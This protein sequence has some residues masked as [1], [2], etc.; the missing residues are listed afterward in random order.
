MNHLSRVE[1]SKFAIEGY[2]IG[3]N[4]LVDNDDDDD[5]DD[6]NIS[7]RTA[8][9]HMTD[10]LDKAEATSSAITGVHAPLTNLSGMTGEGDCDDD[11]AGGGDDD[12]AG[13]DGAGG[14]DDCE[15]ALSRSP[16]CPFSDLQHPTFLTFH[17]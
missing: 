5:I 13:A 8:V 15:L 1:A 3:G 9:D 12:G 17:V 4:M 2:T 6:N 16:P 10:T 14:G 11:G 7:P